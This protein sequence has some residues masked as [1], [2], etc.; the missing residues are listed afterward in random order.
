VRYVL[1]HKHAHITLIS[2]KGYSRRA[3]KQLEK[4]YTLLEDYLSEDPFFAVSYEPVKP[5]RTAPEVAH[6]M[7][8]AAEKAG[9]GP[10]AAVAGTIAEYLGKYILAEGA[11]EVVVENGGDIFLKLNS[12]RKIGIHA[13]E[14]PFSNK[15]A[16]LV[17]PQETPLG[18]CTSAGTVGHSVS[19]GEADAVVAVAKST[20]LA[21]AAATAIGNEVKGKNGAKKGIK[22]AKSIRGLSGVIIIKGRELATWGKL[23]EIVGADFTL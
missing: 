1:D 22:K 10:M 11:R 18:V 5:K 23:P 9:V 6:V 4:I 8:D 21:D 17:K 2:D 20:P 15:L 19:L 3:Q 16:L 14:S 7:A 12:K 13:G